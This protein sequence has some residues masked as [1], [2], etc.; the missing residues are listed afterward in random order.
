MNKI[1]CH[2]CGILKDLSEYHKDRGDSLGVR[3]FCKVCV[4]EDRENNLDLRRAQGRKSYQDNKAWYRARQIATRER[5]NKYSRDKYAEMKAVP[6]FIL[7]HR[8]SVAIRKALKN[9]AKKRQHWE[10]LVGYTLEQL[11][12]HIEKQFK[13]GMSWDNMGEWE[14]DHKIPKVAFNY[15]K[16]EDIDFKRCWALSNLQPL[17]S[18]DNRSKRA[19]LLKPHQPSLTLP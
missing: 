12:A 15:E 1:I 10:D 13:V 6:S 5:T 17:W 7:D 19:K 2:K 14:I 4:K 16:P 18:T 8:M 3:R 11:K 9:G